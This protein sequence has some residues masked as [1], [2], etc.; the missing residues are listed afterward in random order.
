MGLINQNTQKAFKR[1]LKKSNV[2]V[3]INVTQD[4]YTKL[5]IEV[6]NMTPPEQLIS[7]GFSRDEG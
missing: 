4:L 1:N 7:S 3:L 6:T 2:V 5:L